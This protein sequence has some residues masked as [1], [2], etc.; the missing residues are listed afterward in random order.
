MAT[1][2]NYKDC[3]LQELGT[4][5]RDCEVTPGVLDG[6]FLVSKSWSHDPTTETFNDAYITAQIKAGNITPFFDAIGFQNNFTERGIFTSQTGRNVKTSNGL[7]GWIMDFSNGPYFH[8]AAYYRNSY[9]KYNLVLRYDNGVL[10]MAQTGDGNYKGFSLG[11]F[12][13]DNWMGADGSDPNKTPIMLALTNADQYNKD[14]VYLDPTANSFDLDTHSGVYDVTITHVSNA[15]ADVV[16]DIF[17]TANGAIP[18][19]G[20]EVGDFRAIGTAIAISSVADDSAG[21]Y[22][23]TFA[24]DVS[25]DY[26][27]LKIGLYDTSDST[28]VVNKSGTLYKGTSAAAA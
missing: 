15:T 3:D 19:Q 18:I 13:V 20:L 2:G 22:T 26:S 27:G 5:F 14:I 11:L 25:G 28:L 12:D 16:V 17:A 7:P 23:I 24:S 1:L 10:G 6:F 9:N 4:G 21:R 8:K